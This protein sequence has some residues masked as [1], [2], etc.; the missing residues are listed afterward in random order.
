MCV[1]VWKRTGVIFTVSLAFSLLNMNMSD[2]F[3]MN[4][5]DHAQEESIKVHLKAKLH[6]LMS[7]VLTLDVCEGLQFF[8]S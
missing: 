4:L 8:T 5:L 2:W 1:C 3:L 7:D 6:T